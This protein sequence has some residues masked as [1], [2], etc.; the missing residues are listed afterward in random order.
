MLI[1]LD[2]HGFDAITHFLVFIRLWVYESELRTQL[3]PYEPWQS[4]FNSES[5][6]HIVAC[7]DH[8]HVPYSYWYILKFRTVS[9]FNLLHIIIQDN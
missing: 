5:S 1:V 8:L 6:C 2:Q 4:L 9:Y 3:L 7:L